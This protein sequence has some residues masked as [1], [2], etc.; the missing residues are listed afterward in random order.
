LQNDTGKTKLQGNSEEEMHYRPR[1][2]EARLRALGSHFK[3]VLVTG[4]RQ[5]GKSTLLAHVFPEIKNITFDPVQDL[6]GVRKDPD[7]FLDNFPPP[8]I[9][10]EI[11][12]VPELFPALKRRM[13]QNPGT[14]QYFL[15]GSQ[16]LTL[17]RRL[18][19]SLAGRIAILPL[20]PMT[21]LEVMGHGD[22]PFWLAKY[23]ENPS[24]WTHGVY[25]IPILPHGVFWYLW[26]GWLPGTLD[27]PDELIP[28]FCHS[29]MTTYIE[30]DVCLQGEIRDIMEFSRFVGLVSAYTA[31]EINYSNLGR[32]IG[33][34]PRTARSWLDI[35][36]AC[37][38]WR[39]IPAYN[40][41][42]IKRIAN[43]PKG[44]L[45]DCGFACWLQRISS[46]TALATSPFLGALFETMVVNYLLTL[47]D[48]LTIPPRAWHWRT[49]GGAEVD[50]VLERDGRLFPIEIKCKTNL[51]GHDTRGIRAFYGTY[52]E[53]VQPGLIFYAGKEVYKVSEQVTAI[54]WQIR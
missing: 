12:Y 49:S 36:K 50:L 18:T 51:T 46:P 39:E 35:L 30:R 2:I 41:N 23:L 20:G 1:H 29:Y 6:Y 47:S 44:Y 28:D 5:V 38:Q 33:I 48:T 3:G 40:G 7:L 16:H 52:G 21:P 37:F 25:D 45:G 24:S 14:G 8:L 27:L 4:A 9:L 15:S 13:D 26:R 11:Q 10:D 17:L 31:Q 19:E 43:K 54:P 42:A 53:R 32:E 34:M 22:G